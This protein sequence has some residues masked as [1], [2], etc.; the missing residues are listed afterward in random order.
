MI[1][2]RPFVRDIGRGFIQHC[3]SQEI[4]GFC[5]SLSLGRMGFQESKVSKLP[6][7]HENTYIHDLKKEYASRLIVLEQ[8]D[9]AAA[10]IR[11]GGA[12]AIPPRPSVVCP[13]VHRNSKYGGRCPRY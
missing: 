8:G 12:L 9:T 3:Q 5:S 10:A 7:R 13:A 1:S 6:N 4:G 11:I 2:L